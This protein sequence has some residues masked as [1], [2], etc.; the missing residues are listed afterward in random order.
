MIIY[1]ATKQQFLGDAFDRDIEEVVELAYRGRTGSRP[2]PGEIR[3]WRESLL[4]M[5]KVLRDDGIPADCGVAIEY[6]I[7][8]TTKRVDFIVTGHSGENEPTA[9]IVELK[10][11]SAAR[12]TD[13]DGIIV[14]HR[15][16]RAGETEGPH[17]SYQ[18][19]SYA[20]LLKGFNEAVY[21]GGVR[22]QPC[23]YLHNYGPSDGVIDHPAYRPHIER[24]PLFLK[25]EFERRRLQAFILRHV[26]KG[27]RGELLYRIDH[28]R[29]RPSKSLA[30][31]VLGLLQGKAEFVL[32]DDQK[33]V[34]ETAV[35]RVGLAGR[36][37]SRKQVY[38][39]RG[40]PGT[41]K[42]VVAVNLL[43][44]LTGLGLNVRYVS[45]NAAPRAVYE[46]RLAGSFRR[47]EIGNLF[48]GSGSFTNTEADS[49]DALVVD[50][51]HRLNERSGLYGNLGENQIKELIAA[52]RCTIF[53][54]DDDQRV[55]LKDIG[56]SE[57]LADWARAL[58]AD[59][60]EDALSSQFR[61]NGSD[62]YLAWLDD[63]LDIRSTAN[64]LL[65][66]T[67]FDFRVVDSP[68]ELHAL[69]EAR[70]RVANR[71]RVVA[72]YCWDWKSKRDPAAWDIEMPGFGYRRRWNLTRDGSLWMVAPE[73]VSEVGCIHTCQGLEVDTIGVIIGPDLVL[74]DGRPQTRPGARARTDQ[75]LR[76]LAS[77]RR[78]DRATADELADR[79]VKNTYRTLMTRGLKGCYVYC[80]DPALAAYLR[81]R[82]AAPSGVTAPA[83]G[84]AV[85]P[86]RRISRSERSAGM[87]A[88]PLVDLRF[89]AGAF[90]EWQTLDADWDEWVELPEPLQ[91]RP[92][93]FVAQVVGES[94]NRRIPNGAWCLFRLDPQGTRQGRVVVAECRGVSD[95]DTG[96]RYTVKVYTSS[97]VA[98]EDGSWRHTRIE[99]RPDS[100][101]PR[102]Q[103]I[104][105]VGAEEGEF[106]VVAELVAI[107]GPM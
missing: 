27:D 1:Q 78:R 48:S 99:L 63:T 18:A 14:A 88:V 45:K 83:A 93:Y 71:A 4:H 7:P 105:I 89:A 8:Q 106:R 2:A 58:G 44:R 46:A 72:G 90:G 32:V 100:T 6:R 77:L 80:V 57:A 70:N 17:P 82:I 40:G 29:I 51:A 38:I 85:L 28:G 52:A 33:L 39:V 103:P 53:F 30:D 3:A 9:V 26:R 59:V 11:W 5:A 31:S 42:S 81:E 19:W 41:G 13:K 25:G 12:F 49:F 21:G 97:K 61:C 98:D 101:D 94:M 104:V 75:S 35:Q 56:E 96:G 34:F 64:E 68:V 73:S 36:Q 65:D 24:A 92:G 67:D 84:A 102:F 69:I 15:G 107:I 23:A 43:A 66:P 62:G 37:G 95:P 86:F 47:T 54:V 55:T 20:A 91:A 22:L 79:I 10:Q 60:K 16:G 74:R 50:E 87:A 76:G